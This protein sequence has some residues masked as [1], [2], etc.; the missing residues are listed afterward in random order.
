MI[1]RLR[2]GAIMP[3][4]I[5]SH[6]QI[7]IVVHQ[8]PHRAKKL[9]LIRLLPPHPSHRQSK[10]KYKRGGV[11]LFLL[12]YIQEGELIRNRDSNL[13]KRLTKIIIVLKK[14]ENFVSIRERQQKS[15]IKAIVENSRL[16]LV[17]AFLI[18]LHSLFNDW[19][20][21]IQII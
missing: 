16:R 6:Q 9:N 20:N 21:P 14:N 7:A 12:L 8:L 15:P 2:A 3:G 17:N 1:F 11:F 4:V 19:A 13:L 18:S 10:W 5:E